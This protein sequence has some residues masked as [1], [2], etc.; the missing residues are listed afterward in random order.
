MF[1]YARPRACSGSARE[2]L[3]SNIML[4]STVVTVS[5]INFTLKCF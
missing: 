1:A 4:I 2:T 3:A 5:Q